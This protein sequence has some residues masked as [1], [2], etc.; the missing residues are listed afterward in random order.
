MKSSSKLAARVM[1]AVTIIAA[2]SMLIGCRSDST[3]WKRDVLA[4]GGA[5]VATARTRQEGGFGS[6]WVET[7]VSVKRLDGSVNGGKP[8][9][10]LSYPGGG[11]ISKAYV[12]S[13]QNADTDLQV[14]WSTPTLLQIYHRS[15]VNLDLEVVRFANIDIS[16]RQGS[17]QP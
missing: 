11:T 17:S 8:F 14:T 3:V 7:T 6:A 2:L 13:D 15:N 4:P 5:W 12:L 16:F 1:S 10:V 9:D